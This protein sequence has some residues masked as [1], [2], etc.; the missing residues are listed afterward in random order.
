MINKINTKK[1]QLIKILKLINI[2]MTAAFEN[3]VWS[4]S[5]S[6]IWKYILLVMNFYKINL[7]ICFIRLQLKF[8]RGNMVSLNAQAP[9]PYSPLTPLIRAWLLLLKTIIQPSIRG[10]KTIKTSHVVMIKNETFIRLRFLINEPWSNDCTLRSFSFF[11]FLYQMF[12]TQR[13]Y[14]YL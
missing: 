5:N 11:H 4:Y 8:F 1:I 10:C 7:I 13:T 9:K 2:N 3:Q 14:T 12:Y 6:N